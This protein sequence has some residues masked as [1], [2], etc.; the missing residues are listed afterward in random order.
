M[1]H[2]LPTAQGTTFSGELGLV[3]V[4]PD[5]ID[6]ACCRCPQ[7][8]RGRHSLVGVHTGLQGH[9]YR[10]RRRRDERLRRRLGR[11]HGLDG[12]RFHIVILLVLGAASGTGLGEPM[13]VVLDHD[14][15][16][17]DRQIRVPEEGHDG[18]EDDPKSE[19]HEAL[20]HELDR[21]PDRRAVL[22]RA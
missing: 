7:S 16:G 17:H 15:V 4:L 18:L 14:R 20:V 6:K 10:R 12:V 2:E 21:K 13:G 3:C 11:G 9:A 22:P 8:M 1:I 5:D 19:R